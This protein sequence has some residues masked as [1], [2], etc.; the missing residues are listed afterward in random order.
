[1]DI[2]NKLPFK[3]IN[4]KEMTLYLDSIMKDMINYDIRCDMDDI[5][6]IVQNNSLFYIWSYTTLNRT[7]SIKELTSNFIES[8]AKKYNTEANIKSMII[9]WSF[10]SYVSFID[11]VDA[12]ELINDSMQNNIEILYAVKFDITNIKHESSLTIIAF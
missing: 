5:N 8:C 2:E 1:M 11:I 10:S 6:N 4:K 12:S 7:N 3:S 9:V